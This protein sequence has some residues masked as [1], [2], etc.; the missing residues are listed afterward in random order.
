MKFISK[1]SF[2]SSV[3]FVVFFLF[4]NLMIF[5]N[6]NAQDIEF[7]KKNFTDETGFNQAVQNIKKGDDLFSKQKKWL[8]PQA[9]EYYLKANS[10]NPN[11]SILNFKIGVCYL[12]SSD[13]AASLDY[14]LKS[15]S[16]KSDVDSKIEYAIGQGYHYNL[17]FDNAIEHYKKFESAYIGSDKTEISK[18]INKKISEC[19]NG[20]L[21]VS[22]PVNVKIENNSIVNSVH[23]DY[24]PLITSDE[25]LMIFTSRREGS[26]GGEI[27]P[28][29]L[30]YYEDIYQSTKG[31]NGWLMPQK[32]NG[33]V[34]T[35]SHDASVGLSFNGKLLFIYRGLINGG[36]LYEY[37]FNNGE[38]S[39]PKA[40]SKINTSSHESSA[41]ISDDGKTLYIVSNRD[42]KTFGLRDIFVSHLSDNGDWSDPEN[43]GSDVNTIYDEEGVSLSKDGKTLYFSSTGHNSMGG[44]DMFRT[45]LVD[46][47]WSKPE[48][49][50]FPLNTPDNEMYCQVFGENE[51]EHG[52]FSA[53]RKDGLGFIDIYS[54]QKI[55]DLAMVNKTDTVD[56]PDNYRIPVD[57]GEPSNL[58]VNVNNGGEEKKD[59]I[60]SENK[61]EIQPVLNNDPIVENKSEAVVSNEV[62]TDVVAK[63]DDT[64]QTKSDQ[65]ISSSN[66]AFK[67]QVGACHREIPYAEL[68]QRY[69]GKREISMENHEG[70]YKY[71]IGSYDKY[72]SAKQERI[73]C[74]TPDAWIV[75]YKDGKRVHISEVINT[76]SWYPLNKVLINM[77]S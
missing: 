74:G 40:L 72:S 46:G 39:S 29:E 2:G 22:N 57:N 19:E 77:L 4:V 5:V 60:K 3:K 47:K 28:N 76:L 67:V 70:W 35:S 9:L 27:D 24:A 23:S 62:K 64:N 73:S 6:V 65:I 26:T 56:N 36:D 1:L 42:D 69:P 10:F 17:Q 25:K 8:Y 48:N 53:I 15:Q 54:F 52:Y 66:V 11:Y 20:K 59:T 43:L 38:W 34:N 21:L 30:E 61:T 75:V 18:Q 68:H 63:N 51:N 31:E 16:L 33:N 7:K 41:C 32:I 13:K 12:N 50:G 49:L 58:F 71:L 14:F 45:N 55:Q 44:F 37:E